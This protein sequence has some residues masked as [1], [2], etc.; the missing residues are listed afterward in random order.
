MEPVGSLRIFF[1][2]ADGSENLCS[3]CVRAQGRGSG[4]V[5]R[6]RNGLHLIL[7]SIALT[8]SNLFPHAK[9]RAALRLN[10]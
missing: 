3:V 5:G 2:M 7:P 10:F 1:S 8:F 6:P 9:Y 4:V